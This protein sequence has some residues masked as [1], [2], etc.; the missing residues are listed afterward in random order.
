M[1]PKIVAEVFL[2]FFVA[3]ITLILWFVAPLVTV[4][5]AI[6]VLYLVFLRWGWKRGD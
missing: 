1:I 2:Y 6:I 5:F 4:R 3:I